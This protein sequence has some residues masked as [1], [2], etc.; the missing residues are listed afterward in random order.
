MTPARQSASTPSD[1][2][3]PR[4]Q[5]ADTQTTRPNAIEA[6]P[7]VS[8]PFALGE[9]VAGSYLLNEHLGRG[10]MGVVYGAR[11]ER[12][13]RSVAL[14]VSLDPRWAQAVRAEALALAAVRHPGV[15]RVFAS[16]EHRGQDYFVMER[17]VG[18]SLQERLDD[19]RRRGRRLSIE[20]ALDVLIGLAD[21]LTATHATGVAHRDLKP[22]NVMLCGAR[23]VLLDFGL[24]VAECAIGE[25]QGV[26]GSAEYMAPEVISQRVTPGGGA[27]VDLYALGT[28]AFELVVGHTPF[29]GANLQRTLTDHLLTQA[30]RVER[31]DAPPA[32]VDLIEELLAKDPGDRPSSAEAVLWQL[33]AIR[34]PRGGLAGVRP[35]HV[36]VLDDDREIASVLRRSLKASM[37]QLTVEAETD[38]AVA[39]EQIE[40]EPP[41]VVLLDL[42]MPKMNGV[43]VAMSLH[44]L[45]HDR[46]P[47]LVGMSGDAS[48]D[49]VAVMRAVGVEAFVP[50]DMRFLARMTAVVGQIRQGG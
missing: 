15:V 33:C 42:H 23:V 29:G 38:P 31:P 8:E 32:L 6:G 37:P 28:I 36:L 2:P 50:K 3:P 17:L 44:A 4:P 16:G 14:K 12:L 43:E 27:L 35:L 25:D 47:R 19:T 10:G 40:R 20:E 48:A 34:S 24:V 49:D 21:A 45:P 9:L 26:A 30:P 11:D 41:D 7:S 13:A 22:G 5:G 1:T 39:L 18:R 46:R